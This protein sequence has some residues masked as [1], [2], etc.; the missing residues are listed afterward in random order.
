[1][2]P[3]TRQPPQGAALALRVLRVGQWR[4]FVVLPAAA[5]VVGS[6][7]PLQL[8]VL[9]VAVASVAAA[10]CMA[11]AYG[12]NA[13]SDRPD[14]FDPEKNPL[15]GTL[16]PPVAVYASVWGCAVAALALGLW[17]GPVGGA[18][19]ALSLVASLVYSVGPR[20]KAKP[21]LGALTNGCIFTPLL[22]FAV[23]RPEDLRSLGGL[24]LVFF[25]LLLQ[26]Q[27]IHEV[28]DR[29]EDAAR[30]RTTALML[31]ARG[32]LQLA[33]VSG[34]VGSVLVAFLP[35]SVER[36]PGALGLIAG[37]LLALR[38][39]A[40]PRARRRHRWLSMTTGAAMFAL[41]MWRGGGA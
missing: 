1:M 27:L 40:V 30:N 25:V 35:G 33:A 9:E 34:V 23:E 19:V 36:V 17:L 16:K 18:A 31:G 22:A 20:F 8:R 38:A 15:A 21:V 13:V 5:L 7:S 10:L 6:S 41:T 28:D 2:S 24:T 12:L 29:L 4:H 14:D 32:A 11:F 3:G 39:D 37:G 26:N